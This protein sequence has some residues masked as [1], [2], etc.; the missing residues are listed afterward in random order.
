MALYY[1][2]PRLKTYSHFLLVVGAA[3]SSSLF[4]DAS[5]WAMIQTIRTRGRHT[6]LKT[7][8]TGFGARIKCTA[9]WF[10]A[11]GAAP[12]FHAP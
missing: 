5:T 9:R 8:D 2:A 4:K 12:P 7:L 10:S 6:G 1:E 11:S 3:T